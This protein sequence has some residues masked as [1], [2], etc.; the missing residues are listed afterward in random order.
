MLVDML[1][2]TRKV[3]D[4]SAHKNIASSASSARTTTTKLD[5]VLSQHAMDAH[6]DPVILRNMDGY[7]L[8]VHAILESAMHQ[9]VRKTKTD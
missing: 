1:V 3:R 2:N 7:A 6:A 9:F 4:R 5:R 8:H